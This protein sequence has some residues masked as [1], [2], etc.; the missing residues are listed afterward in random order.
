VV[1]LQEVLGADGG[2]AN[3]RIARVGDSQLSLFRHTISFLLPIVRVDK[4]RVFAL[5]SSMRTV[6][7]RSFSI[8]LQAYES[9]RGRL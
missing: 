8:F 5:R 9:S 6:S 4:V 3:R 1:E 2:F 7:S